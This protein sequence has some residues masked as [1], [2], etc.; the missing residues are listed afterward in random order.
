MSISLYPTKQ[1][2]GLYNPKPEWDVH[3]WRPLG[4]LAAQPRSFV[5][6]P[7]IY[8]RLLREAAAMG[9]IVDFMLAW[10]F[11]RTMADA[12]VIYATF[13]DHK[14]FV[15]Y[16]CK[17]IIGLPLVVTI[18]AYELYQNPNPRLFRRALAACDQIITVTEYNREIL[19][20]RYG[21]DPGRVAVVRITVDTER[22]RPADKFVILIVAYFVEKKGHDV[23]FE[24]VRRLGRDDIE[25]WV[26]GDVGPGEPVVDAR[27]LAARRGVESQVVFFGALGGQALEALYRACDV[28][29]LP[30][31]HDSLGGAEGFPTA[32]A[33]AMAFGKP[34]ISTRHVE[35][36]RIL[37]EILVDEKDP[38]GLAL[39]ID[40]LYRSPEERAR[41]GAKNRRI[42]EERFSLR[43]TDQTAAILS[44]LAAG[45]GR[46]TLTLA[47]SAATAGT[48][49]QYAVPGT[50]EHGE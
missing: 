16:F 21:V 37:D 29:C 11:A 26:V 1:A 42:A 3:R 36:P 43:N 24:A 20:E 14:L 8:L 23:L 28:F 15:G 38:E 32:I 2:T 50:R 30:S 17:R 39:A 46:D 12:S 45:A 48:G 40:Y 49:Q 35:I 19:A 4:V 25:V 13:G 7:G 27:A 31:H 10:Y 22:Y 34:V 41:L 6:A 9:A 18:H 5:R 33:E 47:A 44:G